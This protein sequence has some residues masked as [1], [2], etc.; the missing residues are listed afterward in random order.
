MNQSV[1]KI[2][3]GCLSAGLLFNTSISYASIPVIDTENISQQIKTY[4]QT[5]KV[6]TNT[7]AQIELQ[8]KELESLPTTEL[9]TFINSL[10]SSM[11]TVKS[12][13][14]SS[15]FFTNTSTWSA[16]WN[17][18][19]PSISTN[20][21]SQNT[22]T[23]KKL[24]TSTLSVLSTQNTANVATYHKLIT[25]L[26]NSNTRLAELMNE[27]KSVTG[28]KQA[29]QI[30]NEIAA[31]KVHIE[32]IQTS[33]QALQAQNEAMNNQ[34]KIIAKQNHQAV[35]DAESK[36]ETTAISDMNSEVDAKGS[37][38]DDPF[39]KYGSSYDSWF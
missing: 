31:E 25:E 26:N 13:M 2:V 23:E 33:L 22:A 24:N 30:S 28:N 6:V 8:V 36:A 27:N 3:S 19:F 12:S 5:V 7:A 29:M 4:V 21:Y 1:R 32:A 14:S 37:A 39:E 9:N 35:A 18:V 16:Y 10:K 34:A 11:S 38:I 15:N 17:K 20:G